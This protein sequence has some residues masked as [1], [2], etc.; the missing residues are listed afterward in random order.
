MQNEAKESEKRLVEILNGLTLAQ[1]LCHT[2]AKDRGWHTDIE[3]GKPKLV[4]FPTC[5]ALIH[6]ELSEALEAFRKN[7]QDEKL[8]HRL[9]IEVELTDAVIRIL[10]LAEAYGLDIAEAL[11]EKCHY[12]AK[13]ADHD[14]E[15]RKAKNGKKF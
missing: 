10:D 12:N 1:L 14:M 2:I 4:D 11:L 9:G 13:R 7:E 5:I 6:S 15:A 3:T 8:P